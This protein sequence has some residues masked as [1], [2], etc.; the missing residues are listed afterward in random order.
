MLSPIFQKGKQ[1]FVESKVVQLVKTQISN[2]GVASAK[3]HV[4]SS[5]E[6][7]TVLGLCL[8]FLKT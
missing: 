7:H 4:M 1:R 5:W 8:L 2:Q 6:C 3:A